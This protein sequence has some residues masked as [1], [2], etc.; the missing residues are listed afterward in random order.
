MVYVRS[1]PKGHGQHNQV[2]GGYKEGARV[3]IIEDLVNQGK[4]LGEGIE[5]VKNAGLEIAG[6]FSIV[7]YE[8]VNSK[9]VLHE[10]LLELSSLTDFTSIV[11]VALDQGA[12]DAKGKDI[13]QTWD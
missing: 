11:Q 8:M 3:I 2:E 6:V 4:S 13:L 7:D 9:R 10:N 1:K 12:I 5:G